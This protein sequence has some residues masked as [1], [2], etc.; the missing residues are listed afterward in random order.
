MNYRCAFKQ[1]ALLLLTLSGLLVAIG[2]WSLSR[3]IMD[4]AREGTAALAL[5]LSA[6][7]GAT[8]GSGLWWWSRRSSALIG[9]REAM[10]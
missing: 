9:R 10:L 8:L 3:V 4:E 1:F 7:I 2:A 6:G 5:M